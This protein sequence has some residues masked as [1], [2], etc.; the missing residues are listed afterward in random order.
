MKELYGVIGYTDVPEEVIHG[1]LNDIRTSVEFLVPW[2]GIKPI[3]SSLVAVYDWM[4]DNGANYEVV[5]IA[6]GSPC[7]RALREKASLVSEVDS[8][9]EEIIDRLY[10]ALPAGFALIS[11]DEE[12]P[13]NSMATATTCIIKGIP[14]LELTAGLVPI[15]LEEEVEFEKSVAEVKIEGIDNL[16]PKDWDQETLN[17][18]PASSVKKLARD[19]GYT[20]KTKDEAIK[21]LKGKAYVVASDRDEVIGKI[22]IS[23]ADGSEL[24]FS[25]NQKLL[26]EIM[27]V[28]V[29]H[30]NSM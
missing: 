28:V 7:P 17:I 3:P 23:L 19:A 29:K 20:V 30:Q 21:A 27:D 15:I 12:S 8:P 6:D 11:W 16:D 22:S 13:E 2:Y 24:L 4:I 18:M 26:K 10:K 25:V 5:A 1:S 9:S 14:A